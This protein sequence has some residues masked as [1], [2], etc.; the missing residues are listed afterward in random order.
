MVTGRAR[1][2]APR[3]GPGA[4]IVA[5]T[6]STPEPVVPDTDSNTAVGADTDSPATDSPAT[7]GPGAQAGQVALRGSHRP[8]V[9][10]LDGVRPVDPAATVELTLVLRRRAPLPAAVVTGPRIVRGADF[11]A[12]Y[13]AAPD[14]VRA[15]TAV[16]DGAGLQV[17]SVDPAARTMDVA[18]PVAAATAL[19]GTDLVEATGAVGGPLRY[20]SGE[21]TVPVALDRVVTAVLGL[22]QRPQARTRHRIAAAREVGY[23]VPELGAVY[24]FPAGTDGTGQ[25]VAIVELG[26]G[27]GTADL[28]AYFGGLS[29]ATPTVTAVGVDGATNVVGGDPQGADGEVLL[30]VEVVGALA[31]G[32]RIAVYFAPNTDRGF[33]DAITKAVHATPTPAALSISWGGPEDSWTAQARTAMDEAFAD[34]A[35]LGVSV[36]VAAGDSGSSDGATDGTA[37]VDFPASSPHVLA[38]GGT[39]LHTSTTTGTVSTEVVWSTDGATGG[40]VSLE[41]PLPAWQTEAG[42][43]ARAAGGA[44]R[45]VPD[46]AADADPATGYQVLVDGQRLVIGGTSAVAPL[47]AAL[48]ARLVQAGGAPLGLL[49]PLLYPGVAAG[50]TPPGFRDITSGGNGAYRAKRGWDPCTGLGVPDGTALAA[51]LAPATPPA[52]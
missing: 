7:D 45:G 17:R 52:A 42:V 19:F 38:C 36:T 13:G 30:D 11:A 34:A 32:A 2:Q 50:T 46:V 1:R 3:A 37:H 20:R 26:G 10:G 16:L 6:A 8:A 4:R 51:R 22:D 21:L 14:D 41:F 27:F 31:N 28:A 15:V 49:A 23:T 35:A 48:A 44:G 43:P 25:T 39:S 29:L 24:G 12:A 18:G 9:P 40:G 47:W 33:L 5:M